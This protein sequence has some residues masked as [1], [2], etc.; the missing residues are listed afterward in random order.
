MEGREMARTFIKIDT[1]MAG[2]THAGLLR[3]FV[4]Q[5][6]ANYELGARILAIMG[7]NNDGTVWTDIE[8]LFGLPP[9]KG[10]TIFNLVNG[11]V[12]AL[13]GTFQNNNGKSIGELVG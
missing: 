6:R 11:T 2:A 5:Q 4:Q 3:A 1:T 8:A 10:Q 7:N 13:D 12:G 9:G